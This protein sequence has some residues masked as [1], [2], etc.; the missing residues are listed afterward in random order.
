VGKLDSLVHDCSDRRRIILKQL[1]ERKSQDSAFNGGKG[2]EGV[3]GGNRLEAAIEVLAGVENA[4][5]NRAPEFG[6]PPGGHLAVFA[7]D[8]PQ[9]AIVGILGIVAG[10]LS[11]IEGLENEDAGATQ[12]VVGHAITMPP[13]TWMHWPVM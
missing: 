7:G 5:E 12:Y 4:P 2:P 9:A 13:S 8:V 6:G 10:G 11:F 1:P 3:P